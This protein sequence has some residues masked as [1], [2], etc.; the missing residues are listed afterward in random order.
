MNNEC[1]V[2]VGVCMGGVCMGGWLAMGWRRGEIV[3]LEVCRK[4]YWIG[5]V[6]EG[7]MCV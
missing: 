7:S 3:C 4:N 5:C 6:H 1:G 2:C